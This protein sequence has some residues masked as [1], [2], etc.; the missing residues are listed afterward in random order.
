[1]PSASTDM[2]DFCCF[3]CRKTAFTSHYDHV[4]GD[5]SQTLSVVDCDACG[6][7]QLSRPL[8]DV[9][10]YEQDRQVFSSIE[11][12]GTPFKRFIE[13]SWLQARRRVQ[14]VQADGLLPK[15]ADMPIALDVGG[16]YGF[17]SHLL[18]QAEPHLHV[19]VLDPSQGR[20]DAGN[21]L[22]EEY[23]AALCHN[24]YTCAQLDSAF[25]TEQA[26]SFDLV[27][28]WHVAEHVPDPVQLVKDA[29][30]L[31]IPGGWL[32]LEVPNADDELLT[33]STAFARYSYMIEHLSYFSPMTLKVMIEQATGQTP[34]ALY[35]YQRYGIFNY[36][37]WIHA[38][39]PLGNDPD[40]F[41]GEDRW[42]LEETWRKQREEALTTDALVVNIQ[43]PE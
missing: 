3:L 24:H 9:A 21:K 42:W 38:N 32:S 2:N 28:L 34:H 37:H 4:R 13:H 14:R 11:E 23:D 29:W 19:S 30:E 20:I 18:K 8:Y 25:A 22:I 33:R 6:H 7:R 10:L 31:V 1:M 41:P 26:A 39:A 5:A 36:M 17:F 27:T 40:F 35:G 12:C 16:G 43:K 15:Q